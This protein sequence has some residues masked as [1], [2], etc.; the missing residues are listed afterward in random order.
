[1]LL[2]NWRLQHIVSCYCFPF[3][4]WVSSQSCFYLSF[5]VRNLSRLFVFYVLSR[6]PAT[7]LITTLDGTMHL[8]ESAS[9]KLIWSL[10]TGG[11]IY[12]AYQS[13][14]ASMFMECGDEWELVH[15]DT[16]FGKKVFSFHTSYKFIL[17]LYVMLCNAGYMGRDLWATR[18]T[19][20]PCRLGVLK[21][22]NYLI[23]GL[24][25]KKN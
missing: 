17:I 24:F 16:K 18:L 10:S 25:Y 15:H 1:M 23:A 3:I 21:N 11:Q 7:T 9:G 8:V 5:L 13:P 20:G 19:C 6:K 4:V 22:E 2:S 12:D 14:A